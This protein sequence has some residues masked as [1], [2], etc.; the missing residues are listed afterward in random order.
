MISPSRRSLPSKHADIHAVIGIGTRDPSSRAVAD[1]LFR[2]V[3]NW[4][5]HDRMI[6]HYELEETLKEAIVAQSELLSRRL[7]G[8]NEVIQRRACQ[9][10]LTSDL[11]FFPA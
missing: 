4:D 9:W 10:R 11:V 8:G 3:G 7:G 2:P 6:V 1:G 5:G